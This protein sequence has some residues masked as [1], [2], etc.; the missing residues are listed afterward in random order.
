MKVIMFCL[1]LMLCVSCNKKDVIVLKNEGKYVIEKNDDTIHIRSIQN[2]K[3]ILAENFHNVNGEYYDDR[4][5]LVLSTQKTYF[6]EDTCYGR[7]P[8][9]LQ[10]YIHEV[11]DSGVLKKIGH[12]KKRIFV[13]GY[14]TPRPFEKDALDLIIEYYYDEKYNI[15]QIRREEYV[16]YVAKW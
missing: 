12:P 14:Y 11:T 13:S 2:G 7:I 8:E 3:C 1:V 16:P 15:L 10:V 9:I 4:N 5:D 6:K